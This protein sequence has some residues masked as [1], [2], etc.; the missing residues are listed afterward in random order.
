MYIKRANTDLG[1]D[2][3]L[4]MMFN[5]DTMKNGLVVATVMVITIVIII[6]TI[7]DRVQGRGVIVHVPMEDTTTTGTLVI[8]T[9]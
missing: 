3:Q 1:F 5:F 2:Y 9:L 6:M 7:M 4:F 8:P